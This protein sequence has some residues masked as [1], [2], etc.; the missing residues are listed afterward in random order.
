M[1]NANADGAS[2]ELT[3]HDNDTWLGERL[4]LIVWTEDL[5]RDPQMRE[6]I[7]AF[8]SALSPAEKNQLVGG[9]IQCVDANL[10]LPMAW[11]KF[12][13]EKVDEK[14][15]KKIRNR[16]EDD[17]PIRTYRRASVITEEFV[18]QTIEVHNGKNF[19]SVYIREEM[20][21]RR[22]GEFAPTRKFRSHGGTKEK[23]LPVRKRK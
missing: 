18:G 7:D 14:L 8:Q 12:L 13:E 17:P 1:Q 19:I 6:A 9:D 21:G 15:L 20:V 11:G 2:L 3:I 23:V 22:L 10:N 4:V 16:K 5:D